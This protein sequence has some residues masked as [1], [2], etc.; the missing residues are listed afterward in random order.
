MHIVTYPP[1]SSLLE[2]SSTMSSEHPYTCLRGLSR[3]QGPGHTLP[4]LRVC[5]QK[6]TLRTEIM[7]PSGT[8]QSLFTVGYK[9][10]FPKL[11]VLCNSATHCMF[12]WPPGPLW[13]V[14]VR[15]GRGRGKRN[16]ANV[17]VVMLLAVLCVLRSFLSEVWVDSFCQHLRNGN[18]LMY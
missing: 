3:N 1:T 14:L 6:W 13:V 17:L 16:Q 2:R 8:K 15:L 7:S 11:R 12:R 4:S 5:L 9:T 18:G 10:V